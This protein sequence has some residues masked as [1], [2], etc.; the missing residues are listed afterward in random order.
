MQTSCEAKISESLKEL[1][2]MW[3]AGDDAVET[4]EEETGIRAAAWAWAR[5][6][7]RRHVVLMTS[8]RCILTTGRDSGT[9]IANWARNTL[10]ASY[11]KRRL[12]HSP[13]LV[14]PGIL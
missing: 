6:H 9:R 12:R 14:T 13:G 3:A 10:F 4:L 11:I 1:R 2:E 5:A 7:R 8:V